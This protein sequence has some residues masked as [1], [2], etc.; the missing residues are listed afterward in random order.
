MNEIVTDKKDINNEFFKNYFKYENRLFSVKDLIS[1][2]QNKNEKL[3][4]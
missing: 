4:K 2:K 1:A 3:V